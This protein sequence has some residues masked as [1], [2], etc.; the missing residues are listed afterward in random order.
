M[1]SGIGMLAGVEALR[2]VY[3]ALVGVAAWYLGSLVVASTTGCH[4][5][6]QLLVEGPVE[7]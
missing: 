4:R 3:T 2:G 5:E 1:F 6:A 7:S